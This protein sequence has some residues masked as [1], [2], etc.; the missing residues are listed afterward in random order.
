M[1]KTIFTL[2]IAATAF[3]ACKEETPSD[4]EGKVCDE[5]FHSVMISFTSKTGT[6]VP[7]KNYSAVNQRT[8]DTLKSPLMAT[9]DLIPGSYVAVDDSHRTKL[10]AEGDD[11]KISGTYEATGQTKTATIKVTGG[12]CACHIAKVSGPDKIAFD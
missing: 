10:S 2:L 8:G 7:V 1:Y 11:I 6:G 4:C 3:S 9:I 12:K 5:S